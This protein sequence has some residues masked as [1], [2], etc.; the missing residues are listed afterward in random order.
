[1]TRDEHLEWCKTRALEYCDD[2]DLQG[3]FASFQSDMTKHDETRNHVALSLMNRMMFGGMMKTPGSMRHF[4]E[5]F[6]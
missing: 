3:A 4:I 5:G 6:N 1:M 2:G